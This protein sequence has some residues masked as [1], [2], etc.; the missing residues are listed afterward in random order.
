MA[1]NINLINFRQ[2]VGLSLKDMAAA[3]GISK[4]Y[5]EKIESGKRNPSYNFIEKFKMQFQNVDADALFFTN[6]LH[7]SCDNRITQIIRVS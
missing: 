4:S 6:I 3:V 2:S 1:R 5:Y 7:D